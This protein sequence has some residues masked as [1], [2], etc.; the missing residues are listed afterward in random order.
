MF[1]IYAIYSRLLGNDHGRRNYVPAITKTYFCK[2]RL[3]LG[4]GH[5]T[6]QRSALLYAVRTIVT[7]HNTEERFFH[8]SPCWGLITG[9]QQQFSPN[10]IDSWIKEF[11]QCSG[12]F[13]IV[14]WEL[15][16]PRHGDSSRTQRKVN[17]HCWELE[18]CCQPT[19]LKTWLWTLEYV[20]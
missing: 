19:A 10:L 16:Q 9:R 11:T 6:Q 12:T 7:R 17:V 2:Q 1:Q 18:S 14:S 3:F 15:V 5:P 13:S 8:C 4:N 20:Q